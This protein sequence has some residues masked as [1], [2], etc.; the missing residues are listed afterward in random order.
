MRRRSR[1]APSPPAPEGPVRRVL[2]PAQAQLVAALEPEVVYSGGLGGGKSVG[3]C[4]K[5]LIVAQ[6][7]PGTTV[8]VCRK[9]LKSLRATTMRTFFDEVCPR[10]HILDF[11][12]TD[13]IVEVIAGPDGSQKSYIRFFGLTNEKGES[14]NVRSLKLGFAAVDQAEELEEREFDEIANRLRDEKS[15]LRQIIAACNPASRGHWLYQRFFDHPVTGVHRAISVRSFDNPHLPAD[16]LAR[17][18]RLTG[19]YYQR[20]ALGEWVGLEGLVYDVYDPTVHMLTWEQVFRRW[21]LRMPDEGDRDEP[22]AWARALPKDWL[23]IVGIDW[24][25][26]NPCAI[27]WLIQTPT[28]EWIRYRE[29]YHT[30]VLVEDHARHMLK[31]S[32]GEHITRIFPDPAGPQERATMRRVFLQ[33]TGEDA[34]TGRMLA[35]ALAK[36]NNAIESGIEHVYALLTPDEETQRAGLYFVRDALVEE[37]P[38]LAAEK[39]PRCTEEEMGVYKRPPGSSAKNPKE[40]PIDKDNHGVAATRYALFSWARHEY[41]NEV[42]ERTELERV[43]I[44]RVELERER[45]ELARE[46]LERL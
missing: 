5:G 19:R 40:E 16:Y 12:K 13:G 26:T 38:Y 15:G 20:Y 24:G 25:W 36:S 41:A 14:T 3:I 10:D 39:L 18:R 21:H 22:Q 33:A 44:Q 6:R 35:R 43:D 31:L 8:G 29:I 45:P 32:R 23:R 9:K 30:R 28:G 34:A 1:G 4:A 11:N 2:I 27:L 7:Y 37:D 42:Q 46:D 17:L